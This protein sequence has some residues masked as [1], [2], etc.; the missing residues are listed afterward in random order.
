MKIETI[1]Y[2]IEGEFSADA[3]QMLADY[4]AEETTDGSIDGCCH[5]LRTREI[6]SGVYEYTTTGMDDIRNM[7]ADLGEMAAEGGYHHNRTMGFHVHLGFGGEYPSEL[8]WYRFAHE[9]QDA[10]A[11][12]FPAV[13]AARSRNRYCRVVASNAGLLDRNRYHAINPTAYDHHKTLEF[14]IFPAD[15]PAKMLEYL[16]F[17]LRIVSEWLAQDHSFGR[18][19]LIAGSGRVRVE[20][21]AEKLE[22]KKITYV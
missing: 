22:K 8:V 3:L 16:E 19:G 1:G 10:I 18:S 2:E 17:T 14:R 4:G 11:R 7:F 21:P 5:K 6:R 9:F 12:E 13:Y 15:D 20:I